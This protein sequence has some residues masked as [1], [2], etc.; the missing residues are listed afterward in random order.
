MNFSKHL[1]IK[2][3]EF[4]PTVTKKGI[5][6]WTDN[7]NS[8]LQAYIYVPCLPKQVHAQNFS[9]LELIHNN[10]FS[11]ILRDSKLGISVFHFKMRSKRQSQPELR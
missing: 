4:I 9:R 7:L 5:R 11:L 8:L 10:F 3:G 1:G 6:K 2:K